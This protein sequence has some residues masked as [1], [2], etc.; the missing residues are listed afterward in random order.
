MVIFMKLNAIFSDNMI[1]QANKPVYVFGSGRGNALIKIG[2]YTGEVASVEENWLVELPAFDYGGP[3]K[4][5]AVLNDEVVELQNIYFG[6]VYLL[7]GQSN[8]QF[9]M[10]Q[11]NT[12]KEYYKNN[13][14]LRLFTVDQIEDHGVHK[15]T[16]DGWKSFDANG[17][18]KDLEGEHYSSNDGWKSAE[19]DLVDFW[20]ALGYLFGD[21]LLKQSDRKI[22]LISCYQGASV[23]QSWLPEYFLDNTDFFVPLEK[24]SGSARYGPYS[25]WNKDGALYNEMLKHIIPYSLK[26]VI[27]YQGESNSDGD[28]S[29]IEI[30]SGI[31]KLLIEKWRCD[32]KD[33]LLP[34]VVIQ[35]HDLINYQNYKNGTWQNIQ[36]AQEIVC[37][38]VNYTYLVKSAD[39]C[40]TD[41]IHPKTK[42]PLALRIAEILKRI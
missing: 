12:P 36:A 39:I 37:N 22:G 41:N 35:I 32:F 27:W 7:S 9:K 21:E 5:T 29:S 19:K 16:E 33:M 14:S 20:P 30:Y 6:D 26:A 38:S 34:F 4:M 31:L 40:E 8:N 10:W 28:D 1:L 15:L 13:D 11:T 42:L 24:R 17:N 2:D 18:E 23:I 25:L 3:Y